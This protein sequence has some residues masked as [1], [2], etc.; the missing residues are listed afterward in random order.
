MAGKYVVVDVE[1]TGNSYV[2]GSRVIQISAVTVENSRITDQYTSFV[3]PEVPIPSF[4]KELTGIGEEEVAEAPRFGEIAGVIHSILDGAIF[5]AHNVKFDRSFIAGELEDAGFANPIEKTLD[6]VELANILLPKANSYKLEELSDQME[7]EHITPHQADS[8]ALATAELLLMLLEKAKNLPMATLEKLCELSKNLNSSMFSFFESVKKEK[9]SRLESLPE[10][11]ESFRGIVLKNKQMP[12]G[13]APIRS[14]D[15]PKGID[16]K[17]KLLQPLFKE[18]ESRNGQYEMMDTVY[19]SFR[20][21]THSVIEAGTGIGK[22][23][24]YLLPSV[25]FSVGRQEKVII[26]TYTIQLQHQ[27]LEKE[28][29]ILKDAVPFSYRTALIKGREHYINMLKFEQTLK[30]PDSSYDETITKMKILIWLLQTET[31]DMDELNLSSGGKLYWKRICNDGSFVDRNND[32]WTSRDFYLHSKNLAESADIIITNHSMLVADLEHPVLPKSH[33]I[34]IDEAHHLEKSVRTKL[35]R[36]LDYNHI[37]FLLGKLG[38]TEKKKR[39]YTLERYTAKASAVPSVHSFAVDHAIQN[40]EAETDD[41]FTLLS[42][43]LKRTRPNKGKN[44]RAK[45][46]VSDQIRSGGSWQK[47]MMCAERFLDFHKLISQGIQERLMLIKKSQASLSPAELAFLEE[48]AGFHGEWTEM[49]LQVKHLLSQS[50]NSDVMWLES[51]Q[52]CMANRTSVHRQP[53]NINCFLSERLFK[54]HK[55]VVLTSASLTVNNS[56]K[57]FS[58][59]IGIHSFDRIETRFESP[60]PYEKQVKLL[61]PTDLPEI[62]SVPM[63]EYAESIACH[64]IAV[65]NAAEGRMLVL[66]T[67][68]EMLRKT[69]ELLYDS[70]ELRDFVLLAHGVSSG[71]RSR[72]VKSF[73]HFQKAILLGTNSFWEGIDIPGED[74]SCLVVV[75]LPFSPI[76]DPVTAAKL[77]YVQA[78][79]KNPFSAYSLPEAIIQFKQ[80]FGRLIRKKTDRGVFFVFDQR[81]ITSAYG[82]AFLKSIPSIKL[83][84]GPLD[85]LIPS[86]ESWLDKK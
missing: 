85:H 50:E 54:E 73:R 21:S 57:F 75:R 47:V 9:E 24:A 3:N 43:M 44:R 41:L 83:E 60:F 36:K 10:G 48:M 19:Q 79:G 30:E 58:E 7:L 66:F 52:K 23:I 11:L 55:S 64:L 15:Y 34:V 5:V 72:L 78:G 37:K 35:G 12:A 16:D 28:I 65:A 45:L 70:N 40:I 76:D 71:S 27:I 6:T 26:S 46:R 74:L 53:L 1:T 84:K 81:V 51:D 18:F 2:K 31:G 49:G 69:H 8:D 4:I 42:Q 17:V 56:F 86:V 13:E 68:H 22:T 80:G 39:F 61:V 59:E 62:N 29:K 63:E 67:S 20:T 32:P 25:Y 33:F 38:T 82:K 77:E 14:L